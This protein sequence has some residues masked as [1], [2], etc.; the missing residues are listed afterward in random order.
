MQLDSKTRAVVKTIPK[1]KE[2]TDLEKSIVLFVSR[3]QGN[4]I[5]INKLSGSLGINQSLSSRILSGLEDDG[6]IL[7][8][9]NGKNRKERYI[10][11]TSLGDEVIDGLKNKDNKHALVMFL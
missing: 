4:N 1:Y 11:L 3:Q 2:L 7:K 8:T 5:T 6:L 10:S 9:R